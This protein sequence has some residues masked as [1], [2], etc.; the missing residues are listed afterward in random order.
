MPQ[1]ARI[2]FD[3]VERPFIVVNLSGEE[4]ELPVTLDSSDLELVGQH[5]EPADG[6]LALMAKYLGDVVYRLGDYDLKRLLS[7]WNQQREALGE[8]D[9]GES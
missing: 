9:L 7:V 3:T 6:M 5:D 1:V 4:H 8:P 2:D